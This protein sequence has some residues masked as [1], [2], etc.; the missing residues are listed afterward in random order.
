MLGEA[1]IV[2]LSCDLWSVSP[3]GLLSIKTL[4]VS[5]GLW[6]VKDV[7]S[8]CSFHTFYFCVWNMPDVYLFISL[9]L[10]GEHCGP[11]LSHAPHGY[12]LARSCIRLLKSKGLYRH[13]QQ[14]SSWPVL[15]SRSPFNTVSS[16]T[17][18][19]D[20]PTPAPP[21]VCHGNMSVW[22]TQSTWPSTSFTSIWI[23]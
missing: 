15:W 7:R 3:Y 21:A 18:N 19:R 12:I 17:W 2:A 20:R 9:Y 5:S 23:P 6:R 16:L 13:L 4:P 14:T 11:W 8:M 1:F 22:T 10:R